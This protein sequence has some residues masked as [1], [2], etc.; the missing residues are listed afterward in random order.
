[1]AAT[2]PQP[3]AEQIEYWN[4]RAGP[5]WVA[6]EALLDQLIGPLG[7]LAMNRSGL[8]A[9][10]S[11]LDVGCGC[12]HTS[13]ELAERVGATGT[14]TGIDISKVMLERARFHAEGLTHV[15][16]E[17]ADA[18]IAA[19]PAAHFDLVYSRFGVMFFADP[20]AAFANLRSSLKPGGRL[21]FVCW[22]E[23]ARN[24]WMRVPLAAA[25]QHVALPAPPEPDAPGPFSFADDER[26]RRIL[27]SAGFDAVAF[28]SIEGP[29]RVGGGGDVD[30]AVAFLLEV[31]PLSRVAQEVAPAEREAV[32]GAV[33]EALAPFA[34][35]DG[36]QLGS[37][38][39]IVTA[40]SR[41]SL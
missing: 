38:A 21:A 8:A 16:F 4:E 22:Q 11:V 19:L 41:R 32:V 7:Q 3:N 25:A 24:E 36:V 40:T 35:R 12:G 10:Q 23:L 5:R 27:E 34:R 39:W 30:Q 28:E 33:R 2:E 18:Q 15:G 6:A 26:V 1:M 37:A 9:G 13:L 31:G 14:V 29:L 17:H 20:E